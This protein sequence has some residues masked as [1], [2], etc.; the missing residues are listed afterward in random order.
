MELLSL[1]LQIDLQT[2]SYRFKFW[3]AITPYEWIES[4]TGKHFIVTLLFQYSLV[5]LFY[6]VCLSKGELNYMMDVIEYLFG[7][8]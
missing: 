8:K 5:Y 1:C 3:F 4:Y 6:V 2:S 7:Y